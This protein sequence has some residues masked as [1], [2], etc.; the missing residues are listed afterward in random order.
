LPGS[1]TNLQ[2][3]HLAVLSMRNNFLASLLVLL[4]PAGFS[5]VV[6]TD[7]G[8]PLDNHPVTVFF[9][10][11]RGNKGLMN[12]SG[13][14]VYAHTGV[15]TDKSTS[16]TDWKYVKAKWEINLPSC[17]LVKNSADEYQFT[18][19]PDIRTFYG[20]P[21]NEKI[22]KLA[23]VFRNSDGSIKGRD[24]GGTDIFANVYAEGLNVSFINP[25]ERFS[26]ISGTTEIPIKI[27]ATGADSLLLYQDGTLIHK[28]ASLSFETVLT[29]QDHQNHCLI[30]RAIKGLDS[31]RDTT[32]LMVT[33]N[34]SQLPLPAGLKDGIT[35]P[36][37]DS[38]VFVLFAPLKSSVYLLGDFNDWMPDSVFQLKKDGDRFWLGIGNLIP[39]K[40][41]A[42]QYMVDGKIRIADPYSEKIL[43]PD[44]DKYIPASVYPNLL[45][46]PFGKTQGITGVIQPGKAHFNWN[47]TTY[48]PPRPENLIIYELLIR[49]FIQSHDIKDVAEKLDY[50]QTLGVNAIE[51]MPFSEFEGNSSWGYNP[52]F[53]FAPD[54]YYGQDTDFKAFIDECHKR[55]M[56]VFMD[57]VLNHAYGQNPMVQMYFDKDAGKPTAQ[58][59]WFN[60]NSPNPVFAW[61]NDFNHESPA[62]RYFVDRVIEYW[63]NEYKLDGFRFDFTKGFTNTPGDGSAYDASRIAILERIYDKIK[64]VNP[65][66][67]MIC[68]HFAPN[69]EEKELSG[70]GL[71]L[72]GNCNYNYNEATMGYVQN[73]DLSGA[74][75]VAR[76]WYNPGLVSYM[77]SHDEERLMYKNLSYGNSSGSYNIKDLK[78]AL[79]R[80]E[81][82]GVFFFSIPGP[83]MIWQFGELGY[84]VSIDENGRVGEKPI[85]WEYYDQPDRQKLYLTWAKILDIRKKYS[86]FQTN[87]FSNIN[88]GNDVA[89]KRIVLSDNGDYVVV[90]GNFGVTSTTI[91][92]GFTLTG[93]WHELFSGDSVYVSDIT[94]PISLNPGEYRLY[95]NIKM[96]SVISGVRNL[97]KDFAEVYPNPATDRIY[98]T[99]E[100][101]VKWIRVINSMG[102]EVIARNCPGEDHSIDISGIPRGLYIMEITQKDK[103]TA[104]KFV[105]R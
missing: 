15:I 83:K 18:I 5:Q 70:Y 81:L 104:A 44:N 14:D 98:F 32:W 41:Y 75:Y 49:D 46:Y 80:E 43:D 91:Q 45:S 8:L 76:G 48:Q 52:S 64:S 35:Y 36:A 38:A 26:L 51:L 55:G 100:E 24:E 78:T 99:A 10:A 71:M 23:F 33:G 40:E 82:A 74:S 21:A 94:A 3:K 62:T 63:L 22:L 57:I 102:Q 25:S 1:L 84:D 39:G 61:G 73:S 86:V 56:A 59:P 9:H 47:V 69:A 66:A 72:W 60:V 68:E 37:T 79:E 58:N 29:I 90:I 16:S 87:D 17:K 12:Y 53:Y 93:W 6:T 20:V 7:P 77:E 89:A 30:A 31:A 2:D 88:V 101:N 13:T 27:S 95:T 105:K 54:K 28:S 19:T 103:T 97:H 67:D 50:L 92:P 11:D 4:C 85:R 96:T 34:T 65:S 42:F